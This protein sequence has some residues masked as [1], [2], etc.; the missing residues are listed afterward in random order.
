MVRTA[1]SGSRSV[2]ASGSR[3][4]ASSLLAQGDVPAPSEAFWSPTAI[5]GWPGWTWDGTTLRGMWQEWP[6]SRLTAGCPN[7]CERPPG[8]GCTCGVY[9][10]IQRS[11]VAFF[12]VVGRV[13]L[14]GRVIEHEHGYRAEHARIRTLHAP[15]HLVAP[16]AAAYP[17]WR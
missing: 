8:W 12:E 6:I 14:T 17:T 2:A 16:I 3:P 4:A 7:G 5:T 11:L 9:A 10:T 1:S 13:E 15:R